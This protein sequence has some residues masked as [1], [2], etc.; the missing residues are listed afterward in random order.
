MQAIPFLKM[1]GA[2]N[3]FVVFDARQA[4][5]TMTP[6]V[7]RKIADR[8]FG[9]GCDQ[10]IVLEPSRE[11]DAFMRIYNPDGS[12]SGA[13]GNAARCVGA[14]LIAGL[15]RNDCRI[16]TLF[17][18]LTAQSAADGLVTVDMGVPQLDW[19]QIPLAHATDTLHVD[20]SPAPGLSDPVCVSMGN[21]HAV[22]FVADADAIDV[23]ALGP[24]IEH[25][26][27]FP[28]RANISFASLNEDGSIRLRVWER[29]AGMTQACG[30]AACATVVAASRRGLVDRSAKLVMDGG[31][32][33]VTW[34]P[35][36]HAMLTGP[37]AVAFT[38]FAPPDLLAA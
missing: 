20:F 17:G 5:I 2:G 4:L 35:D 26:P 8:R 6:A 31:T 30:S 14:L 12:E 25:D 32:L 29:G 15:G 22:F 18:V 1:H 7:A 36:G 13:C 19:Q 16:E 28:Q 23:P 24:A 21:P 37:V 3:D 34:A 33:S 9:V 10:L 27:L 38:G 11:A